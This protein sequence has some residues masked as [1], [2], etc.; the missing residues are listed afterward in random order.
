MRAMVN[1]S[2]RRSSRHFLVVIFILR[3]IS[4]VTGQDNR[5][6]C[7]VPSVKALEA[8]SLTCNFPEDISQ[9]R[10]DVS[11]YLY[12]ESENPDAILDCWWL[13]GQVDCYSAPGY[14]HTKSISRQLTVTIPRAAANQT[15]TYACQVAGYGP[16][17]LSTCDFKIQSGTKTIC[18]APSVT[19][20]SPAW[21][22]CYFSENVGESKK[23]FTVYHVSNKGSQEKV[24]TCTWNQGEW[25]CFAAR[26]YHLDRRITNTAT[27]KIP[28]VSAS[29]TG[30]YFCQLAGATRGD[31]EDCVFNLDKGQATFCN[32]PPVKS[33]EMAKLTCSFP[34]DV[35]KTK[36]NFNI[37]HF[38][39]QNKAVPDSG[40]NSNVSVVAGVLIPL[41]VFV[42]I[43]VGILLYLRLSVRKAQNEEHQ[44]MLP[45]Q[46]TDVTTERLQES[47]SASIQTMYP[48]ILTACYFVPSLYINRNTYENDKVAGEKVVVIKPT[49]DDTLRH[50]HAIQ[51]VLNCLRHLADRDQQ[52]M[53][54]LSQFTC[55]DYLASVDEQFS[56]HKLPMP[57]DLTRRDTDYENFDVLIVHRHYGVVVVVVKASVCTADMGVEI[58]DNERVVQDLHEAVKQLDGAERMLKHLMADV[59]PDIAIRKTLMLPNLSQKLFEDIFAKHQDVAKALRHCTGLT[60]LSDI[61]RGCLCADQLHGNNMVDQLQKWLRVRHTSLA[62]HSLSENNYQTILSR[63]CGVATRPYLTL[64]DGRRVCT[65]SSL[66]QA[67]SLTGELFNGAIIHPEH[68]QLVTAAPPRVFLSGP[69]GSGKTTSLVLMGKQWLSEG[70]KVCVLSTWRENRTSSKFLYAMLK[71]FSERMDKSHAPKDLK[72]LPQSIKVETKNT[73]RDI[74]LIFEEVDL[75]KKEMKKIIK[76]IA[77]L[78]ASDGLLILVDDAGP[79]REDQLLFKSFCE[80]LVD[81]NLKLHLWAA[82]CFTHQTPNGWDEKHFQRT[83]SCP[84]TIL[85]EKNVLTLAQ[86]N[87]CKNLVKWDPDNIGVAPT[88]GLPVKYVYHHAQDVQGHSRGYPFTCEKCCHDVITLLKALGLETDA[89]DIGGNCQTASTATVNSSNWESTSTPRLYPTDVL[90]LLEHEDCKDIYNTIFCKILIRTG[91]SV[92]VGNNEDSD[93]S[94]QIVGH[95]LWMSNATH[96]RGLKRKVMVYV[97]GRGVINVPQEWIR[98][99]GVTSCTSQLIWVKDAAT[100]HPEA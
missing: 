3:I 23:D 87:G 37:V 49:P 28:K 46:V 33:M 100:S 51:H 30:T 85:R 47:L 38:S 11:V 57:S 67:V 58:R 53:F 76:K 22:S 35:N 25:T 78:A 83:V 56:H 44:P 36:T 43:V 4:R 92:K 84:P 81:I 31:F 80:Q 13:G 52:A 63:L 55:D 48:D 94:S 41:I 45:I 91:F 98:L 54:V 6:T 21:L 40:V 20:G 77:Y 34:V 15:G 42:L 7:H 39:D 71:E 74:Q 2:A 70:H 72:V 12:K 69:P 88:E 19:K 24:L 1:S 99:R 65:P 62:E 26:D 50:D 9:T 60:E 89:R 27:V 86:T 79:Y 64:P 5:V 93:F 32:I 10:K 17:Q 66:Q 75:E 96:F 97:E 16:G 18:D 68:Q 95:H 8:T 14:K 90:L 29:H 59:R 61:C 73:K 82:S